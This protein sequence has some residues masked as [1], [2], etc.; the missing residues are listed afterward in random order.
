MTVVADSSG[1][2]AERTGRMAG[3]RAGP[4]GGW[5]HLLLAGLLAALRASV[6]SLVACLVGGALL[7]ATGAA[8]PGIPAV[9]ALGGDLW[10]AAHQVPLLF[11]HGPVSL[12]P[13]GGTLVPL[14]LLFRA[15]NRLARD[16]RVR[17]LRSAALAL[18]ALVLPYAGAGLLVSLATLTQPEHGSV[19]WAPL[20]AGLLAVLAGGAG[21][22][23]GA[24]LGL[25]VAGLVPTGWWP[26]AVGVVGAMATLVTV[27]ALLVAAMLAVQVIKVHEIT[28]S[29]HAGG[30]AGALLFV[31]GAAYVPNA[32]VFAIGYAAGP[33]FSLGAGT[34]FAPGGVTAG[35]VPAF[36][37]LAAVPTSA[38]P[39]AWAVLAGPALAGVVAGTLLVRHTLPRSLPRAALA[40]L[41]AGALVGLLTLLACL[42]AGGSLG[43][44]R[45]AALGPSPL[46][47][48]AAVAVEVAVPAVVTAVLATLVA[49]R[50]TVPDDSAET[51]E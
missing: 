39:W 11:P 18:A 14:L 31:V 38:P 24:D 51:A 44:H 16:V 13:L 1:A 21:V 9:V 17:G 10:L 46:L 23:R 4:P 30:L 28:T 12:L 7:A 29:L 2:R 8:R 43:G 34:L 42:L 50:R 15:G 3:L 36:P 47:T 49:R 6:T 35:P 40:G 37:L 48:S 22:L 5:G 27:G 20:A 32:V 25:R 26:V 41:A 33:G 45:L 19:L